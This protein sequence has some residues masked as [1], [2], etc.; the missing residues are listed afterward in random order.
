MKQSLLYGNID[1]NN[2]DYVAC[3]NVLYYVVDSMHRD[4]IL[5]RIM[6]DG[7]GAI[8]DIPIRELIVGLGVC[9]FWLQDNDLMQISA[10]SLPVR[11]KKIY[12]RSGEYHVEFLVLGSPKSVT[13][14]LHN[15]EKHVEFIDKL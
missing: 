7:K 12:P 10:T 6:G 1:W 8:N 15:I 2:L 9:P 14:Q 4:C 5:L 3:G 11:V 13:Y